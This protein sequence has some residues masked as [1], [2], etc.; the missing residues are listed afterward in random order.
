MSFKNKDR[1]TSQIRYLSLGFTK[2]SKMVVSAYTKNILKT[3]LFQVT[4]FTMVSDFHI[5]DMF[6]DFHICYLEIGLQKYTPNILGSQYICYWS[7]IDGFI[8]HYP[9]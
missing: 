4:L 8:R 3:F 1:L 6:L 7:N 9:K 5:T 2:P